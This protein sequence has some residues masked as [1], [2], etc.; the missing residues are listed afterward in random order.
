MSKIEILG[1]E[2]GAVLAAL[3]NNSNRKE[4]DLWN[5]TLHQ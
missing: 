5:M 1:K 2:K 4:W 3:F